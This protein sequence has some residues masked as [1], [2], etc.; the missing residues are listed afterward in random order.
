L[1]KRKSEVLDQF[2]LFKAMAEKQFQVPLKS[3]QTDGGGEFRALVPY[4][5]Q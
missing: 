5:Q 2:L 3:I 4:F 1:L